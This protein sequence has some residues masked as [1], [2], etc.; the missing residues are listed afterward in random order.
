MSLISIWNFFGRVFY[1]FV[2]ETLLM[3]DQIPRPLMVTIVL[4]IATTGYLLIDF[5][6]PGALYIASVAIGLLYHF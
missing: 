2:S 3:R 6:F 5:P 1:G 4:V